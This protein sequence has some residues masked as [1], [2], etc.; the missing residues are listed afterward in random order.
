MR[1]I[2]EGAQTIMIDSSLLLHLWTE[3]ILII[4]YLKNKSLF[5]AIQDRKVIP[6]EAF[7]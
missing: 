3:G 4:V 2:I 6:K 1:I 5:L 7:I